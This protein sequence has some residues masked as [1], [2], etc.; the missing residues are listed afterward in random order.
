[1][2]GGC[3]IS[4]SSTRAL[5]VRETAD[6][7]SRELVD[8]HHCR[9]GK[10]PDPTTGVLENGWRM[11]RAIIFKLGDHD[12]IGPSG[13]LAQSVARMSS[14]ISPPPVSQPDWS[15]LLLCYEY[16]GDITTRSFEEVS[17]PSLIANNQVGTSLAL[18]FKV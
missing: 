8:M 2:G 10:I 11:N 5:F 6:V 4:P 18:S 7:W 16:E 15:S 9:V 17:S 14:P 12:S 1:M 3:A 13:V